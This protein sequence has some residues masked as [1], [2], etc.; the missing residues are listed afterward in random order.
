MNQEH[1]TAPN[2][3]ASREHGNESIADL[4]RDL[5]TDLSSLLGKE[6]QLAKAEVGESVS[7]AKTAVGAL[8]TGAAIAMAGLVVLLMS[9]V[10]GLSNVVEPW[11]AALIVGAAALLIG[12]V[13]VH[14][15]KGK[16][17]AS[18]MVP[19]RTLDSA[20]KD[21]ETLKRAAR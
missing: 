16:M 9:A 12:Y 6:I 1:E 19:D 8:A 2:V 5:A 20:K 11:L 14:S 15:A 3:P 13:M 17:S 18:S 4:I 7:E 10:Y 21:Q